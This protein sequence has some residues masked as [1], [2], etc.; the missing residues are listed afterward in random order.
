MKAAAPVP[1]RSPRQIDFARAAS[2][3]DL[4]P[5]MA[6]VRSELSFTDG[7]AAPPSPQAFSYYPAARAFFRYRCPCHGCDG[8]FDLSVPVK[9]LSATRGPARR[10]LDDTV[11]CAGQRVRDWQSRM[12]C[13]V[14]ARYRI[15][16]QDID[17]KSTSEK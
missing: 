12:P 16:T 14:Q 13:P 8:E 10:S 17:G 6:E 2:L 1:R 4:Y 3:H 9:N 5:R 15:V 7:T 11:G